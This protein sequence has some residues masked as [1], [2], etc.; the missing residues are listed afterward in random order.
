VATQSE[1][2]LHG[3]AGYAKPVVLVVERLV[4]QLSHHLYGAV[5]LLMLLPA[6]S[7]ALLPVWQVSRHWALTLARARAKLEMK[8]AWHRMGCRLMVARP[9]A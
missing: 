8:L 1:H 7:L 6:R 4:L 9:G 5:L 3:W 2:Q